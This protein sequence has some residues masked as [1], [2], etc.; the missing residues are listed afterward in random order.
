MIPRVAWIGT[1]P[2]QYQVPVFRILAASAE[3]D[4][5]VGFL[6]KHGMHPSYDKEFGRQ[7]QWDTPLLDGYPWELIGDAPMTLAEARKRD[8]VRFIQRTNADIFIVPG[9]NNA[10]LVT[11][12]V[13]ARALGKT[14]AILSDSTSDTSA[15]SPLQNLA[16]VTFLR[17][18]LSNQYA[19]VPGVRA[20]KAILRL[21]VR[22]EHVHVYP[23][24]VDMERLDIAYTNREILRAEARRELGWGDDDVG[25]LFVGKLVER[26]KPL[27]TLAAF[28]QIDALGAKL[29]YIGTGELENELRRRCELVPNAQCIG[30]R[31]QTELPRYYTAADVLVLYSALDT[32]GL[33]VNEAMALGCA[34]LVSDVTGCAPD[35]VM[36]R[37]T[38]WVASIGDV[39]N[40]AATMKEAVGSRSTLHEMG[41]RG[42]ALISSYSPAQAASGV[43]RAARRLSS[44]DG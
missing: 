29:A 4:F 23:H 25:F 32:W 27:Q 26:K 38:G 37:G 12:I 10:L 22:P 7:V 16:K 30:F 9:Y 15:L 13:A 20:R 1:H 31:N 8:V 6:T 18:L 14:C 21:G 28:S 41:L 2:I 36:G 40:L 43:I 44:D 11:A 5:R 35:L 33:V 17:G 39:T 24:C 3:I 42:R 34:V 19:L